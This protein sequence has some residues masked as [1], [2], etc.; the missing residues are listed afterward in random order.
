MFTNVRGSTISLP[1]DEKTAEIESRL[2]MT[3]SEIFADR[4]VRLYRENL[5]Y[6]QRSRHRSAEIVL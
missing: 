3:G 5:S 6:Y 2:N 4:T 1:V